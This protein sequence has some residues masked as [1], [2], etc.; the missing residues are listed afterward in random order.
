MLKAPE[1]ISLLAYTFFLL[2]ASLALIPSLPPHRTKHTAHQ[3]LHLHQL[4]QRHA[5]LTRLLSH[6]AANRMAARKRGPNNESVRLST[7]EREHQENVLTSIVTPDKVSEYH[8]TYK[9]YKKHDPALSFLQQPHTISL[10]IGC[11]VLLVYYAFREQAVSDLATNVK[12][13][14]Q[15]ARARARAATSS[16]PSS[17]S[18]SFVDRAD[19]TVVSSSQRTHGVGRSVPIVLDAADA[20]RPLRAP[21]Q[22][23]LA[24]H[25]GPRGHL[26][27]AAGLP[28]LPGIA[29]WVLA[30]LLAHPFARVTRCILYQY[31]LDDPSGA[32]MFRS[33]DCAQTVDDA[34]QLLAYYDPALGKP[35]PEVS[36]AEDCRFY[37]PE[38][39][40]NK[41]A[42]IWVR[43]STL[44]TW[45]S[46]MASLTS[47][48]RLVA[49]GAR[50]LHCGAPPRLVGQGSADARCVRVL[51]T[52][53]HVRVL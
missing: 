51:G 26:P 46:A 52:Q 53:H 49:C 32:D 40:H 12:T 30:H 41:F 4:P 47:C 28:A 48:R 36:Y 1:A 43:L 34:R 19:R 39:P 17:L 2:L 24:R 14:E 22:G 11:G 23:L 25:H 27:R 6:M 9:L 35:L 7:P 5:P 3:H 37:T 21:A 16:T 20:G 50:S 29:Q 18:F 8:E 10:L 31:L 15:A 45:I 33:N 42:N 44:P 38:N 13:Y